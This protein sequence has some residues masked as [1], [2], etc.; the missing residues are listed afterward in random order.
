L[1]VKG[2]NDDIEEL[3]QMADMVSDLRL[4][5][6]QLNTVDRPPAEEFAHPVTA[7]EMQNIA[8]LFDNRVE[9]IA[10]FSKIMKR[11]T[12]DEESAEERIL[13]LVKR[14]PCT[15]DDIS[16][17]LGFHINEVI[18]H[19]SHLSESESIKQV[20]RGDKWYYEPA[21]R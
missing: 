18:K 13:A 9:I 5:K 8:K 10:D 17:S 1:I 4:D 6:I 14:R 12:H 11:K 16:T 3:K 21:I 2:I 7:D 19:L 20:R 15:A